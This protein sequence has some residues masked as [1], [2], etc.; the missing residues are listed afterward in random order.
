M[1]STLINI[2]RSLLICSRMDYTKWNKIGRG[3]DRSVK[4]ITELELDRLY[5]IESIRKTSTKYGEKVTIC[6]EGNIFCYLPAKLRGF[7]RK[8]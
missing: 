5:R 7:A 8:R 1:L 3:E 4:K 2:I 6:L